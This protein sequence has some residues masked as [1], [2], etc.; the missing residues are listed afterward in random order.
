MALPTSYL[1]SAK[2]LPDML[3]AI[4][5]AQAPK[6]FTQSFLE[7]LEFKSTSDRL[8]IGVL[9]ALGFLDARGTPTQRYFD[10]LDQT[11]SG[12]VLAD[13]IRDAYSDLFQ[14]NRNANDLAATEIKN[15]LRTLTQGQVS[16]SVL[17]K[18]AMTFKALVQ[19]A[20]F[21]AA[22]AGRPSAPTVERE[23]PQPPSDERPAPQPPQSAIAFGGLVYNIQL[24][25][26]E[27]RDQAVFDAL[28]RSLKEHLK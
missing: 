24:V 15:K 17:D 23:T 12:R 8:L 3:E 22:T 16:D 14:V 19:Q 27:S 10:F 6:T 4:K 25:L 21:A 18:M 1:T 11:Q 2:K 5:T 7:S 20:D 28:F 9:K 26:P 13:A